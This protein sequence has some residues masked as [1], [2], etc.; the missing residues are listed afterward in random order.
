[1]TQHIALLIFII[2][3]FEI[4][5]FTRFFKIIKKNISINKKLYKL[6]KNKKIFENR[7]E[8]MIFVYSRIMIFSS[9]KIIIVL[10]LFILIGLIFNYFIKNFDQLALSVFGIIEMSIFFL[11]YYKIRKRYAK[12]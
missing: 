11:I 6:I 2:I 9:F 7:K 5:K 8:K 3:V 10:S 1:M 4:I 12:L